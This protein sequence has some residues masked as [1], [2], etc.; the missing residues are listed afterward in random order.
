MMTKAT[1]PASRKV[2]KM[3]VAMSFSME[4]TGA[5][6]L[7]TRPGLS[8]MSVIG[9]PPVVCS[10]P[11][12]FTF[13]HI[14]KHAHTHTHTPPH[15]THTHTHTQKQKHANTHTHTH[16]QRLNFTVC[17]TSLRQKTTLS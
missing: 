11:P 3:M 14:H 1:H 16:T 8:W 4:S 10:I 9:G 2:L 5:S 17:C 15:P 12:S 7:T 13:S 6:G